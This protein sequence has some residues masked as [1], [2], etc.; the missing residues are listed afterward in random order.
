MTRSRNSRKGAKRSHPCSMHCTICKPRGK[1]KPI[2]RR[3][4]RRRAKAEE[5]KAARQAPKEEA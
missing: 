1:M 5:E 3:E 2:R 4:V